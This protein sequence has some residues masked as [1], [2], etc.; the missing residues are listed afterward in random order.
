M[1]EA[2]QGVTLSII[3]PVYQVENYIEE[4]LDSILKQSFAEFELIL[5]N[6]GSSDSSSAIIDRYAKNDKRIIV[7]HNENGGVSKARNT[8]LEIESGRYVTFVDSDD[9]INQG[10]Y[11]QIINRM[12]E[13]KAAIG[14]CGVEKFRN[15]IDLNNP[16]GDGEITLFKGSAEIFLPVIE[17]HKKFMIGIVCNKVYERIIFEFPV[18]LR[19]KENTKAEDGEII[20][21]IL[22]RCESYIFVNKNFYYY[23]QRNN[24]NITAN[25]GKD[26]GLRKDAV[27]ALLTQLEII[28]GKRYKQKEIKEFLWSTSKI[29]I[30][31]YYVV[32]KDLKNKK[33]ALAILHKIK[34]VIKM[35]ANANAGFIRRI[36][37]NIFYA[38][39]EIFWFTFGIWYK[40]TISAIRNR[41]K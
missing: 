4:C 5:I 41:I 39:P 24:N 18:K 26:L 11:N 13:N 16:K 37:L 21:K 10:M 6:D 38:D 40:P 22:D 25:R 28:K 23:R 1:K 19:F 2:Y 32:G 33:E 12:I 35:A 15:R 8:G 30:H 20:L 29:M 34:P 14:E 7:V 27:N 31:S 9:C 17:V 36:L 3:V